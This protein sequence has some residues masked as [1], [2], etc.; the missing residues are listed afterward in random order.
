MAESALSM[1]LR[2]C[3]PSRKARQWAAAISGGVLGVLLDR[4]SFTDLQPPPRRLELR[5]RH[6]HFEHAVLDGGGRTL[7]LHAFWQRDRPEKA[8]VAAFGSI[9]A[10]LLLL[11]LLLPFAGDR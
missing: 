9:E 4:R 10:L 3:P 5:H 7:D 6:L 8:A 1:G 11:G 2:E